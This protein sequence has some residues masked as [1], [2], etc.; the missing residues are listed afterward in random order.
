MVNSPEHIKSQQA[1]IRPKPKAAQTV[2]DE[3][4]AERISLSRPVVLPP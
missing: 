2:T 1:P 4:D 3:T